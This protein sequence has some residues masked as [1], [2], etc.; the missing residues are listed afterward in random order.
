MGRVKKTQVDWALGSLAQA[1]RLQC[2]PRAKGCRLD[3]GKAGRGRKSRS[4]DHSK[5]R[6]GTDNDSDFNP[7]SNSTGDRLHLRSIAFRTID[8]RRSEFRDIAAVPPGAR[9]PQGEFLGG[10][11]ALPP[12]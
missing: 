5:D 9:K 10:W 6:S 11:G 12:R 1:G 2:A 4:E 8:E 3:S 7:S